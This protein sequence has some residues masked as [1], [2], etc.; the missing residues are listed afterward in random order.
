MKNY[1]S[2][3]STHN[4]ELQKSFTTKNPLTPCIIYLE[5]DA[6]CGEVQLL[7]KPPQFKWKASSQRE[8]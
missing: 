5:L 8:K 7:A 6:S 4:E 3:K 2:R 1:G